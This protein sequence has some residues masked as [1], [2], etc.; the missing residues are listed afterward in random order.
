MG[1]KLLAMKVDE[2]STGIVESKSTLPSAV[3]PEDVSKLSG[4]VFL[5]Q[6]KLLE[7]LGSGAFGVIYKTKDLKHEGSYYGCKVERAETKHPQVIFEARLY[8]FLHNNINRPA[9]GIPRCLY[10][11][12]HGEF[13]IMIM[14]LLGISL[15]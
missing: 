15:E 3:E 10:F 11:A 1:D 9:V 12:R 7:K 6:Y 8:N 4:T 2:T 5:D 14:E 13:N